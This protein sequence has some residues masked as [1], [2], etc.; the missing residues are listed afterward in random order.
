MLPPSRR[1]LLPLILFLLAAALLYLFTLQNSLTLGELHGGDLITHHYAQAQARPANAP[2]YPLYTIGGWLWFHAWRG[3]WPTANPVALLS[4]YSTLWA[5]A[6]LALLFLLLHNLTRGNLVITIGLSAFYAVTYF[7]WYYSV[8]AEQYT[9]TIAQTIAIVALVH[10]WDRQRRHLHLYA[11][12]ILLG[13]SLAHLITVLFVAPGVLLFL[14]RTEPGLLRRSRLL[15][16]SILLALLPLLSYIFVYI[17]GAQHPEWRGVG[18]WPNTWAW[19]LD[20][21]STRQGR[22]EM[23]W[24]LGP[25]AGG[26]PNLIWIEITPLLL[27]LGLV[28]WAL[29]GRRYALLYGLTAAI[30]LLFSYVDRLGNWYQVILPLYPLLL[31]GAGVALDRLWRRY[32]RRL[33]R[34]ALAL[35]LLALIIPKIL[36]N[37]PRADLRDRPDAT[38]LTPGQALLSAQPPPGA[39]ILGDVDEKLALDY[40]TLI[41]RQRPDLRAITTAEIAPT[42]ITARP[43]LVSANAAALAERETALPL[44]F[45][46]WSSNLLATALNDLPASPAADLTPTDHPLG[47]GLRLVG[48]DL[49]SGP[50]PGRWTARLA[51]RSDRPSTYDWEISVRPLARGAELSQQDHPAPALG[52]TPTT[53]LRPGDVVHDAFRFDLPPAS[54]PDALRL[55]LY[56][57]QPD[58][59]FVNL[60]EIELPAGSAN[61]K[62]PDA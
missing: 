39:A 62:A 8:S 52:H 28:G 27:I 9:S 22:G 26:F 21:L 19:F 51:L 35:L 32:P 15:A 45:D 43:L 53:S 33:W 29:L 50:E 55:I 2:G 3:L 44:R 34:G 4:S 56:R 5:L 48:Y 14:L 60:V 41:V 31:L 58:G 37:L 23:T 25:L 6:A 13:L 1:R 12:A 36:A 47:D 42:L 11:L 59:G 7:F 40:L 16:R 61:N 38:G 18:D 54:R 46:A 20:F 10:A 30:Y 57:R 17:R 49:T 24:T